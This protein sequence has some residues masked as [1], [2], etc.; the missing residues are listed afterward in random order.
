MSYSQSEQMAEPTADV[1]SGVKGKRPAGM[2]EADSWGINNP[3]TYR[4][5]IEDAAAGVFICD[6]TGLPLYANEAL[7]IL[8]GYESRISLLEE[9]SGNWSF[10]G[11]RPE[12]VRNL[13][14]KLEKRGEVRGV[15]V[16]SLGRDGSKTWLMLNVSKVYDGKGRFLRTD[17]FV[18]DI[19]G[20]KGL[21]HELVYRTYHDQLTG[22]PNRDFFRQR[23]HASLR[24]AKRSPDYCFTVLY[25][26]LNRFKVINDSYGHAAGDELLR[27]A[28]VRIGKCVRSKDVIARFGG[29]EFA[30]FID[31]VERDADAMEIARRIDQ[32]LRQPILLFEQE[33]RSGASIGIVINAQ[34]YDSPE[35]ILRDADT[36]MYQAKR[37]SSHGGYAVFNSHMRE[38]AMSALLVENDLHGAS[39]RGEIIPY[40]QPLIEGNS[41]RLIGFEALMRWR[42]DGRITTPDVFI[43]VAEDTG[44]IYNLGLDMLRSVCMQVKQWSELDSENPFVAHV[45]I[46]GKQLMNSRFCK[47]VKTVLRDTEVDPRHVVLELTESVFMTYGQDVL[48]AM[49]ELRSIGLQFCLDD[50]GT[51]YS[52]LSYLRQMPL[53]GLKLDRSFVQELGGDGHAAAI[54]RNLVSL[55]HDLGLIVVAEGVEER[56]QLNELMHLG[57]RYVQGYLF[58]KP[59]PPE[60]ANQF[61]LRS[62]ALKTM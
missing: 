21:E 46:S 53:E 41:G 61:M 9:K 44:L 15:E 60:E 23:L 10:L 7:A 13:A 57:C 8:L 56:D 43:K 58:A 4:K 32:T 49:D 50:F 12:D 42:R 33:I 27:L 18:T 34:N 22:L 17:G 59:M 54:I 20:R 19:T 11:I 39:E 40:F 37:R 26:D 36:A 48:E 28:T 31:E 55:A 3:L 2:E 14:D 1:G 25:M 16:E 38:E 62:G 29:D 35:D 45:N 47:D 30:V 24:K 52:S 51:G 6:E 5:L